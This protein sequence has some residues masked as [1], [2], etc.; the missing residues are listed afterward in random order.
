LSHRLVAMLLAVALFW[1]ATFM[2]IKV[3]GRELS[4]VQILWLRLVLGAAIVAPFALLRLGARPLWSE[5]RPVWPRLLAVSAVTFA[6]PTL[7]LAWGQRRIDSG[8]AGVIVAGAPLFAAL[9][10]LRLAR[11]DTVTGLRLVGLF[12][13]FAGVALLVGAQ[14]SGDITAALAV[15]SVGINYAFA[16]VLTG[17]WLGGLHP[18]ASALG[19]LVLAA[20]VLLPL[21]ATQVPSELPGWRVSV[22]MLV[23]G[24]VCTGIGFILWLAVIA[25][26]GAS[27]AVLVNYLVPAVALGYGALIL[28]EPVAPIKLAG[29]LVVLLGVALGSGAIG[30]RRALAPR[31]KVPDPRV[32]SP[33]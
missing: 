24:T 8:L 18:L 10:S 33:S 13:G 12:V 23:L 3:A 7:T 1:G 27:R 19:M 9:L 17:R 6:I 4:A 25:G 16:A 28:D 31:R 14:P 32:D 5:I 30:S 26:A 21:A 15:A 22:S 11:H 20:L 29:L 2:L